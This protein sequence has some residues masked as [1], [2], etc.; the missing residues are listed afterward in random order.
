[1]AG[2]TLNQYLEQILTGSRKIGEGQG[3]CEF[4]LRSLNSYS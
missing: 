3:K 1:M 4:L 2:Y